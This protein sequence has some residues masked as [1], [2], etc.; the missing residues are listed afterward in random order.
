M[1]DFPSAVVLREQGGLLL[2]MRDGLYFMDPVTGAFELFCAPDAER[3]DN[4]SNEA[5]C[6]PTG[7]FWLGTMDNNLYPDGSPRE[8]RNDRG[9]LYRV[10]PTAVSAARS[11]T[12]ACRTHWPGPMAAGRSSSPTP[13]PA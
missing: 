5:K 6:G 12:S 4:R 13:S 8:M 1:P 2:A 7:D 10:L 9:A 11:T 3:P